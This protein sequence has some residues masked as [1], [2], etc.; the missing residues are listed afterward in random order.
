MKCK[1]CG[2][3]YAKS[4]FLR[5]RDIHEAECD[6]VFNDHNW[7]DGDWIDLKEI[8]IEEI[9]LTRMKTQ[10]ITLPASQENL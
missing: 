1:Y 10:N 4:S 9:E 5:N 7:F 3:I 8:T 6:K 2:K